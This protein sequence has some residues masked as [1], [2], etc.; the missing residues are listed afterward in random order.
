MS[1][2]KQRGVAELVVGIP[3]RHFVADRGAHVQQRL[4]LL[5]G[6]AERD[7]ARRMVVHHGVH[8][9]PRFV[10]RAVDEALQIG[11]A[12]A[13]VD[14]RAVEGIFDDVVALDALRRARP[15]QQIMLRIVGMPG[16]D[17]AEGI[18]DALVGQ[19]AI[20][21]HQFFENEIELAHCG[22]SPLSGRD[23]MGRYGVCEPPFGRT[24]MRKTAMQ[25]AV[26]RGTKPPICAMPSRHRAGIQELKPC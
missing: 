3:D 11:R 17:M 20:G 26:R 7:R 6:D 10:D 19:D 22:A 2:T 5:A 24:A 16:A 21:G 4:Q 18:D 8:V 13:L 1:L 14:R 9:R 23:P 15:R 12:A 25:A